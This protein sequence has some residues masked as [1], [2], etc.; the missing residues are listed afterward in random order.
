MPNYNVIISVT[1]PDHEKNKEI[2]DNIQKKIDIKTRKA[3]DFV[4]KQFDVIQKFMEALF[5]EP[6][7]H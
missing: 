1:G 5:E 7:Y 6:T 4:K 2:M 3:P